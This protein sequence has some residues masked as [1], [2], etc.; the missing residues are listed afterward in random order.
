MNKINSDDVYDLIIAT[1]V[2][3]HIIGGI[4]LLAVWLGNLFFW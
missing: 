3:V 1:V 2:V 4:L